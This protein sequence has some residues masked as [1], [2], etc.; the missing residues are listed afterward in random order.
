[1]IPNWDVNFTNCRPWE[2]GGIFPDPGNYFVS[3]KKMNQL[4]KDSFCQ[5]L[6]IVSLRLGQY[7]EVESMNKK[8]QR[9]VIGSLLLR[10]GGV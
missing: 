7:L 6:N 5:T 4:L 3:G 1:M 2:F 9:S 10:L 8:A